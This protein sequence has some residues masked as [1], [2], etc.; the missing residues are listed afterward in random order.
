MKNL[1]LEYN[2]LPYTLIAG[3]IGGGK[4]Y[5]LLNLIEALL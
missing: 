2:A 3:G 1:V 4:T 5:F